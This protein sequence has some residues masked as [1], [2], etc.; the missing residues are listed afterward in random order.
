MQLGRYWSEDLLAKDTQ[1]VVDDAFTFLGLASPGPFATAEGDAVHLLKEFT[2]DEAITHQMHL[3]LKPFDDA[4]VGSPACSC[5]LGLLHALCLD[6]AL[7]GCL[8][9]WSLRHAATQ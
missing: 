4:L 7:V 2:A 6:N 5:F 3:F 1:G 9:R 8:Q